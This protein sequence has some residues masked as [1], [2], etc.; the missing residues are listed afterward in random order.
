V[1]VA[2]AAPAS[3]DEDHALPENPCPAHASRAG[4][5][6]WCHPCADRIVRALDSLPSLAGEL[7]LRGVSDAGRLAAAGEV[8][9]GATRAKVSG[10]PSGSPAWDAADEIIEWAHATEDQLRA[11]LNHSRVGRAVRFHGSAAVRVL[12]LGGS[13]RY[14]REWVSA[15]LAA[16][17]ALEVGRDA[18]ALARR[19]ERAAGFDRLVHHLPVPCPSC[20]TRALTREDGA[21][22]VECRACGRVWP[23]DDYR[24]L[25]VVVAQDYRDVAGR[26]S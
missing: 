6:V 16:P 18:L 26:R 1:T 9:L 17:F 8:D 5:P 20:D 12:T 21:E 25:V 4:A 24:R 7:A 19:A 11:H 14:L 13:V 22:Q 2:D 23:E 10:S 15:L 3:A